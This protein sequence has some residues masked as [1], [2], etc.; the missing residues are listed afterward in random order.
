MRIT[1]NNSVASYNV[2][3]L[4]NAIT[5]WLSADEYE[6][7][8]RPDRACF[9]TNPKTGEVLVVGCKSD[10]PGSVT[11]GSPPRPA[12]SEPVYSIF[13]SKKKFGIEDA[14]TWING[15]NIPGTTR[16]QRQNEYSFGWDITDYEISDGAIEFILPFAFWT[17]VY[18]DEAALAKRLF[19]SKNAGSEDDLPLDLPVDGRKK[20][21]LR[22]VDRNEIFSLLRSK[23]DAI[24]Q[25]VG[26]LRS[27]IDQASHQGISVSAKFDGWN[28]VSI[29][30]VQETDI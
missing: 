4:K 6:R 23:K 27:L 12:S 20:G 29:K 25:L 2:A 16:S 28:G 3:V 13:M 8:G 14:H 11:V 7:F 24:N 17:S 5:L 10:V 19:E 21:S 30:A 1:V 22:P 15:T 18:P 26:Q 9:T